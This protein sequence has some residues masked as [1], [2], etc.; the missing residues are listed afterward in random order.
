MFGI[1]MWEIFYLGAAL[2]YGDSA[3]LQE[4]LTFWPEKPFHMETI[5]PIQ[6]YILL[7]VKKGI[8]DFENSFN[9]LA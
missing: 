4:L 8:E 3:E 5:N 6:T 2:S 7:R 9:F 1:L